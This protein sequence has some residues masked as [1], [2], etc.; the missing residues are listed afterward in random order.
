MLEDF[1]RMVRQVAKTSEQLVRLFEQFRT[2]GPDI[3]VSETEH[4]VKLTIESPSGEKVRHWAV[5]VG[6]EAIY[7][8]GVHQVKATVHDD[9]KRLQQS[10]R[11]EEFIRSIPLSVPVESKPSSIKRDGAALILTFNKLKPRRREGW[12]DLDV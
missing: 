11:L 9:S 2:Q 8:R 3:R 1:D 7:L 10:E 5:K 12:Y 4:A 6:E